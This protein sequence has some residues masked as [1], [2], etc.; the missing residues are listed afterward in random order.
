MLGYE[1]IGGNHNSVRTSY[2]QSNSRAIPDHDG[3]VLKG[4]YPPA[5]SRLWRCRRV[6]GQGVLWVVI[7]H[8]A[9]EATLSWLYL[10]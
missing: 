1:T 3:Y 5:E 7:G 10:C 4:V 2:Q 6:G 9:K 8:N